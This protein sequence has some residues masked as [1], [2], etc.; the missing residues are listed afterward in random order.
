MK[1]YQIQGYLL[2][3]K[4]WVLSL[5]QAGTPRVGWQLVDHREWSMRYVGFDSESKQNFTALWGP[6]TM[7]A[8]IILIQ[9]N[10]PADKLESCGRTLYYTTIQMS[11]FTNAQDWMFFLF[12][13]ITWIITSHL[14]SFCKHNHCQG[15]WS[16]GLRGA[17]AE[18][19]LLELLREHIIK[20]F[21]ICYF[22]LSEKRRQS[23]CEASY[24]SLPFIFWKT[25]PRKFNLYA[26]LSLTWTPKDWLAL[27]VCII[28]K[29]GITLPFF[30][31]LNKDFTS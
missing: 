14:E 15:W 4:I 2:S 3:C 7:N 25:L 27:S 11:S 10:V 24:C 22:T 6:L 30:H 12:L 9:K 29:V 17:W 21:S 16:Q 31:W 28:V 5:L 18:Q 26:N 8:Y 13:P 1:N 20:H 23:N 19:Q